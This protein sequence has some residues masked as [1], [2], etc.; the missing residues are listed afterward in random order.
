MSA[1]PY[2]HFKLSS[3]PR[4]ISQSLRLIA[5]QHGETGKW[6]VSITCR[7]CNFTICDNAGQ[8]NFNRAADDAFAT[9]QAEPRKIMAA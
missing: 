1:K 8:E 2:N 5:I 7:E 4:C 9:W 3:C 6:T